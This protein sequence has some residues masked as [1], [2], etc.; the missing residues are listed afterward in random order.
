MQNEIEKLMRPRAVQ[1][2][3]LV[4][5][6]SLVCECGFREETCEN[7]TVKYFRQLGWK[8][9][10]GTTFCPEC[11]D[12]KRYLEPEPETH[13]PLPATEAEYKGEGK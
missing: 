12:C 4:V 2:S 7:V 9:I 8:K 11:V 3:D 5:A 1:K 6:I 13:L 10:R